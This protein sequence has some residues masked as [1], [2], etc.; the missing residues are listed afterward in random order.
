M[1]IQNHDQAKIQTA[2]FLFRD[3]MRANQAQNKWC[4]VGSMALLTIGGMQVEPH[5][6]DVEV[7]ENSDMEGTFRKMALAYGSHFYEKK[8]DRY[9]AAA[10]KR[11][12][13]PVTWTHKPYIFEIR[14]VKINVWIVTKF[15]NRNVTL[16]DGIRYALPMDVLDRKLAYR[17]PKDVEFGARLLREIAEMMTREERQQ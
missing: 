16:D 2:L 1:D 8:T 6:L 17:R 13:R 3:L 10:E 9:D 11:M 4:V 14:G 12:K 5:D 7:L 15:S